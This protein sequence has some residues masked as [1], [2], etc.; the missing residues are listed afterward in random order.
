[1]LK[2]KLI[3]TLSLFFIIITVFAV[4]SDI[5]IIK[6]KLNNIE[7]VNDKINQIKSLTVLIKELQKERG[8][9][10]LYYSDRNPQYLETLNNQRNILNKL[11]INH[12]QKYK[13]LLKDIS[14]IHTKVAT[15]QYTQKETFYFYTDIILRM[16]NKSGQLLFY[17]N[18][19]DIKNSLIFHQKLNFIQEYTGQLRALVAS[20]LTKKDITKTQYKRVVELNSLIKN[21]TMILTSYTSLNKIN[22][23][24]SI[25][26]TPCVQ[27]THE[28]AEF[29]AKNFV[30]DIE[31]NSMEWFKISTCSVETIYQHVNSY[32]DSLHINAKEINEEIIITLTMH[33]IFWILAVIVAIVVLIVLYRTYKKMLEEHRLLNDYKKAIDNSTIV[34]KTDKKGNI[35]YVN[36]A[37]CDI[38]GYTSDELIG[39]PHNIVRHS[40]VS[41]EIFK[42][43]WK[44]I[45]SGNTWTGV[46]KNLTKDDNPYWVDATISPIYDSDNNLV[47]YIAIRHDLTDTIIM[48]QEI[49][50]TQHELIYRMG[51][52]VE[53]RS[54]ESG[55]HIRR[56]AHYAK[57]L[58]QLHGIDSQTCEELFIASTMHDMG[59]IAIPDS[60]LLKP[61]K[62]DKDE[63]EIMQTHSRIG[64]RILEGSSLP[65]LQIAAKIA[66]EH[67]ER[68][69][70]KGYPRAIKGEDISIYA[71]IVS[72]VD[73]FDALVS[74]RVYKK[75]WDYEKVI[76]LFN[77]ESGYQFDPT[78][79]K[80]FLD[81]VEQFMEIKKEFED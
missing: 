49:Q 27:E 52:S 80:L 31:L 50:N 57:L 29:I 79:M 33:I 40:D 15:N 7:L 41:S 48:N 8:L 69:D 20:I 14:Y 42:N 16:I 74:D 21:H 54:K 73:V 23:L 13:S 36:Q 32:L 46:V 4:W 63:W 47:E 78:L 26:Q 19:K 22:L 12:K 34:S 55:N 60:I 35:T 28:I 77:E 38:S 3:I 75:A 56:V 61:G 11:I 70:G 17:A 66:H 25:K 24:S 64:H 45:Q 44:T 43:L 72:I 51:E 65:I 67:H 1:M 9:T 62:L 2:N 53:S 58:G 10:N 71:R 37:F 18:D 30:V 39:K 76:K 81:N 6:K 59:K 5:S 68:Y